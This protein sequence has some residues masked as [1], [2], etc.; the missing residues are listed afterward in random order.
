MQNKAFPVLPMLG[1]NAASREEKRSD[2]GKPPFRALIQP[3]AMAIATVA[4]VATVRFLLDPLLGEHHPFILF[5]AAVFLASWYGGWK[6]G[7]LALGLGLMTA[8]F[9][10]V[11]PRGSLGLWDMEQQ[12]GIIA[13]ALVG[14]FSIVLIDALNKAK[15]ASEERAIKLHLT[16]DDLRQAKYELEHRVEQR[17]TQ[18]SR[19]NSE[20]QESET[21]A[22]RVAALVG[23]SEDAII[24]K[25]LNGC[26]T[27]WNAGAEHLFGYTA[28]EVIGKHCSLVFL[29]DAEGD[30]AKAERRLR[31]GED[32]PPYETVR[33]TKDGRDIPV[34]ARSS[35][36]KEDDRIIGFSSINRDLQYARGLQEQLRQAQKMEAIGQ[37]AGGVAHDFNNLLT[38]ISGYSEM[39]LADLAPDNPARS[40]LNEI[41]LAGE[42]A[43]SL[44]RQ[45]LIFSRKQVLEPKVVDLN[46][47]VRNAEKMLQRLIG[48]DIG[49]TATLSPNLGHVKVDPGQVEQVIMN[50]A[51]NARD[52]MP[53]GGKI[54]IETA[55]V[56]LDD[57][58]AASHPEVWA[59]RYVLLA[60]SDTGTGMDEATKARIFE[61]FFTTKDVGKGTGLGLAV[62]HGFIKQS[63]GHVAVYTEPGLGTTFKIY[64]PAIEGLRPTGKSNS[65][66]VAIPKGA[67]TI[68]LVE[69]EEAVR[70]LASQILRAAGYSVLEAAHGGDA[71]RLAEAHNGAIHLL[72]SDVV[73][74]EMGGRILGERLAMSRQG[75][76][77]LF[78]SGYT[79][80]AVVRHGVLEADVAFL[81]KPYT[82][83]SLA[84]KVREVLDR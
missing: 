67:E 25:D 1:G 14:I 17:N 41:A 3:Y 38:I 61:P 37:L 26:I 79:D 57:G 52:A 70:R 39:L 31:R 81:Q 45:L 74:P 77:V 53:Q 8:D 35:P 56:D 34:S 43:A 30:I 6:A 22:H 72:V 42:R 54:T 65:G 4:L 19:A 12:V 69:D 50:L 47:T 51:V 18:L 28:E 49:L 73:M 9:L 20:L 23:S 58:Y 15:H 66:I 32:V 29:Q 11:H 33:R 40:L 24:G 59:G 82:P 44:T 10:F 16:Q 2:K 64:L 63:G 5:L 13:Y 55:N 27:D 21:R 75:V 68:L 46:E 80:D 36:I 60:V 76:K 78:V 71:I 83:M 62:V 7:S 48:E 84:K